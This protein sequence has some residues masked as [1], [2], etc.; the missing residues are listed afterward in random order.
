MDEGPTQHVLPTHREGP[1]WWQMGSL[2]VVSAGEAEHF[3]VVWTTYKASTVVLSRID[4]KTPPIL[5]TA[6]PAAGKTTFDKQLVI[7]VMRSP[8]LT[9]LVCVCSMHGNINGP[10][11]AA[12]PHFLHR[13]PLVGG[14]RT[15]S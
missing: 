2:K 14:T 1:N 9:W 5:V 12:A 8:H 11:Q 3:E 6:P 4:L 15:K 13:V 7:H 10:D